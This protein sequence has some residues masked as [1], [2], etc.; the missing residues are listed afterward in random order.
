MMELQELLALIESIAAKDVETGR[1]LKGIVLYLA[2]LERAAPIQP[3]KEA[4]NGN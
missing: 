3:S 1:V 4:S 2:K